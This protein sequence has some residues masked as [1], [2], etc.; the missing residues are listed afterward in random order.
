MTLDQKKAQEIIRE[1]IDRF[2]LS[3]FEASILIDSF[4]EFFR[5]DPHFNETQFE[6]EIH[7]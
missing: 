6:R 3:V 5:S 2:H 1:K 4:R 7:Q